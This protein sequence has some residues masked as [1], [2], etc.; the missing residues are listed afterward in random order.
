[1]TVNI[2]DDLNRL[3]ATFRK[4]AEFAEVK[5]AVDVVAADEEALAMF[6]NFREIQM[7]MQEK[8]MQGE[9]IGGDELEHAQKVAQLAQGNEKIMNMLQAEMK[10]SGL[11]EEVNRV[12]MKPVQEF[13]EKL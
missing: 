11:L 10:L 13:Y 12:L 4:T 3:E 1:M 5:E 6:K 8:Q 7:Q 2:Y 9:E